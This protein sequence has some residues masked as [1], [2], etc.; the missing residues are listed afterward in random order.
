VTPLP[1]AQHARRHDRTSTSANPMNWRPCSA[2]HNI[3][4]NTERNAIRKSKH[5]PNNSN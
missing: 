2:P 1:L 5:D 3:A 4:H